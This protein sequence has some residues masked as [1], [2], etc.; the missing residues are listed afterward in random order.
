MS[1]FPPQSGI[2]VP[3]AEIR[4][5]VSAIFEKAGTSAE[6]ATFMATILTQTDLRGVFSHGTQQTS[7]YARLMLQG[8][9]N[10]RPEVSVVD[11]QGTTRV[12]DGDGGMGHFPC[13]QA[14]LWAIEKAKECGTA[15]ATTR[16][17]FH[18]GAAGK[19]SRLALE[20]DCIAFVT[21]SN[22][23]TPQP[24][25]MILSAGVVS[26]FSFAVPAGQQ[27]PMVPDM[28]SS[29]VGWD[30]EVFAHSPGVYFKE[31]G[32]ATTMSAIGGIMAGVGNS[33]C[34]ESQFI[35]NQGSF[36]AVFDVAR[37]MPL[38]KF[39]AEMDHFI[40]AARQMKPFPGHERA[41]LAGG[42]EHYWEQEYERS[43]IPI[44]PSHQERL[45]EIAA[46]VKIE[47]PFAR[48]EDTRFGEPEKK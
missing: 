43:G 9:V 35:S 38:D 8:K 20:H 17:H 46:E 39:K 33:E 29:F 36:V 37:F 14:T 7:G 1:N 28:A 22:L 4:T 11:E 12:Y 2:R 3:A 42:M 41:E 40:G 24:D 26:P 19:Y 5:L 44:S 45:E 16:N 10:P 32:L 48:Y 25:R 27:P 47:T 15:A 34:V 18:F 23:Y 30:E 21:S 13:Y 31:V 6:D